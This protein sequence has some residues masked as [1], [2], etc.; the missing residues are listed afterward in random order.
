MPNEIT[1]K[2][3]VDLC[4]LPKFDEVQHLITWIHHFDAN[5]VKA[6]TAQTI[7]SFL[8]EVLAWW[9]HKN[10]NK[11]PMKKNREQNSF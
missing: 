9:M 4:N 5:F 3:E 1:K 8:Y 10:P 2:I 7:I 6:K 11:W